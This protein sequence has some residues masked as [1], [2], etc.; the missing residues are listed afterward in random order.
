MAQYSYC[1]IFPAIGVARLGNSEAEFFIGPETPG[2]PPDA[3]GSFK[4]AAGRAKRQAARFR[5]YAFNAEGKAV[6]EVTADHP[7]V[8]SLVWKVTL[9]NRKAEW[10]RFEGAGALARVLNGEAGAP[11]RRNLQVEG[12]KRKALIIGPA[13]AEISGQNQ[14][15]KLLE[16][17][18]LDKP[19]PVLLGQLLTD[20]R[21]RVLVLGGRGESATVAPDNPLRSFANNDNW[22]DDT[23]DGPVTAEVTLT[24]GTKLEVRNRAWVI[25]APPAFSPH[26]H[27]VVTAY[28]A[29]TEAILRHHIPW[30]ESELGPQPAPDTVSFRRDIFPV[31]DRLN[32][33]Q[34]VSQRAQRGHSPGK[35]GGFLTPEFVVTLSNPEA[36]KAQDSPHKSIFNR[37]R[38]P[39]IHPPFDTNPLP[40]SISLPPES[41]EAVN[42]AN[43]SFMPP[44]AGDEGDVTQGDPTTWF[45]LTETQYTRFSL[46]KDGTFENDWPGAP[47]EPEPVDTLDVAEQPAALTEAALAGCQGG[48]FFP[49]IEITSILRYKSFYSEAF[50]LS[51]HHEAG[52]ITKWMALPWQADFYEC[53]D[54]WWPVA[55]PDDVVPESEFERIVQEFPNE[56]DAGVA[57]LLIVRK[58][59]ARGLALALPERP[60]LPGPL[61]AERPSAYQVRCGQ[62]LLKFARNYIAILNGELSPDPNDLT[63]VHQR[64]FSDFLEATILRA[65]IFQLPD[66]KPNESIG[67]Y[68]N[69]L[70]TET[71]RFLRTQTQVPP[72][73]AGQPIGDYAAQLGDVAAQ[74]QVWQGLFDVEWRS[75]T[76]NQGK[77]D[78]VTMWSSLGFVIPRQ[79]GNQTVLVESD[80]PKY[81]LL[82]FREYFYYLQNIQEY[83][84]FLPKAKQLAQ[85]YVDTAKQ[86][87][88]FLQNDPGLGYYS[89]FNYDKITFM[90]RLEKIYEAERKAGLAYDPVTDALFS[91]PERV[92]ERIRQ[93]APFN[94]LDGSWLEKITRSGP[95][96]DIQ[97]FLFEI[98]SDEIG[99]GDPTQ[100]HAN[101]YSDLMH[102]AGIYL[103]PL[104]SRAYSEN[105]D[106]WEGSFTS[107]SYQTAIAMFPEQFYPELLGMTLYLEWEAI[108][109]PA[110]VKLYEYY[111]YN[112]LFYRLHVAIDNP[113]N[114]HG[115]KAR[116]A[117]TRY[118]DNIRSESG[119][120]AMQEHFQRIWTGY[121]AFKFVGG[122]EWLYRFTNPPN[123]YDQ[124]VAM[125]N[126]KRH[127]GQLNHGRRRF[128]PNS[129]NDSFDE[130]E[131][132][133]QQLAGSDLIVRGDAKSSRMFGLM[134][135][136]GPMLKVF[137]PRDRELWAL[138]IN[139]MPR[140]PAG[141]TLS[142]ADAMVVLINR[143]SA[144]AMSVPQHGT[145][146]LTGDISTGSGGQVTVTQ[147]VSW[148]F[149]LGD[150]AALM[151]ALADRRSGWVIPGNPGESR[152]VQEL[153]SGG[154]RMA[155][156]LQN[157]L[158]ELGNKSART[159]I[160]DWISAGCPLPAAPGPAPAMI[161]AMVSVRAPAQPRNLIRAPQR[162]VTADDDYSR[163]VVMRSAV[164]R[165]FSAEQRSQQLRR[166][167][168][169]G[170]GAPH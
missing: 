114:G 92:V 166:R 141:G 125:F 170:G 146:T 28:D 10:H 9:A 107:P 65:P 40:G 61:D 21:G 129:I 70:L 96:N 12:N 77:N 139:S 76:A 24:D 132:F 137:T 20:S 1:K 144:R 133:L 94:Q 25:C 142:P 41:L 46:W 163:E 88:G 44:L 66:P 124:M 136:T 95:I 93:L 69:R 102:S 116:D 79:I 29:M 3:G 97:A 68:H 5:V 117:V 168:G 150:P 30:P 39:I 148:W 158:P 56:I 27:N 111:G 155:R 165:A 8:A 121:L 138:W 13:T 37:L 126:Q 15:S 85:E 154:G 50:R 149:Q 156:F 115:A 14:Q 53:R 99:N 167:Y 106:I 90:A 82:S 49:G 143:F 45:S 33:Y 38:T 4:D 42:Q 152:L 63:Q 73:S 52:D 83:P 112:P 19:S 109:L 51:E 161:R 35:P 62:Q 57:Q 80:R 59:W 104:N 16:G 26:T 140:D 118:L 131:Q 58:P 135:Q 130:P 17:R 123:I 78:L 43:L 134:G 36:A 31:L 7:D 169:P 101:V 22:H 157:T 162:A 84:D 54:H 153:L 108:Y 120:P 6:A 128:G 159:V 147:P 64:Q 160:L 89:Y 18:F 47:P 72:P 110:M 105:M 60:G 75:R 74:N 11:V 103:P 119:E 145:F 98:W 122:D 164:S 91:T 87:A 23:S 48:A 127:F 151:G 34:W 100:N 2:L 71:S 113:V 67:D 81:D 32:G 86:V 55:R